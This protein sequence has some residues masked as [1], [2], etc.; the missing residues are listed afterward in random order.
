MTTQGQMKPEERLVMGFVGVFVAAFAF[1]YATPIQKVL[2]GGV[3][4]TAVVVALLGRN[5]LGG[6]AEG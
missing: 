2:I 6:G 5:P 4:V 3:G 1:A